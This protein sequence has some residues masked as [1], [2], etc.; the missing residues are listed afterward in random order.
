[1]VA[2]IEQAKTGIPD[3]YN[4]EPSGDEWAV[5]VFNTTPIGDRLLTKSEETNMLLLGRTR[6]EIA[7][8]TP[9]ELE[10]EA[11]FVADISDTLLGS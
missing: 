10:E 6:E 11:S 7:G 2:L 8:M 3:G 5:F 4:P 9:M 1:M